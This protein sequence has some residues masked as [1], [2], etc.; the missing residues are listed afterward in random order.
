V[1]KLAFHGG[2]REE[3]VVHTFCAK[4]HCADGTVPVGG[5]SFDLS[6]NLLGTTRDGGWPCQSECGTLFRMSPK[7]KET[8]LHVF[9]QQANC[10][11]GKL[12]E[13]SVLVDG[14][15]NLFGTTVEGGDNGGGT[16]F[17]LNDVFRIVH[18]FCELDRCKDGSFPE[19]PLYADAAGTLYS[20][21]SSSD[22]GAGVVFELTP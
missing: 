19:S 16:V 10:A 11:D 7:G 5:L 17:E 1:Y 4:A 20:T 14:S 8:V 13:A 12:P 21:T 6:G 15:G 22:S 9:C 2:S 18:S 3:T